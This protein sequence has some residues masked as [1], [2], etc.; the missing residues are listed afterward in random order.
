MPAPL[1]CP[2][3]S[4][5][6]DLPG[7]TIP[8]DK[9]EQYERHFQT[10]AVCQALLDHIDESVQTLVT[11]V[12]EVGA[13]PAGPDDPILRETLERL[14]EVKALPGTPS[15]ERTDLYFLRPGKR[16]GILGMLG[17][18]EV[19]EVI[20]RGGMGIVLKAFDPA[21][22]RPVAIKVMATAALLGSA[23]A[24][25]RFAR[26]AQAAA[27]V[28]HENV[29]TV[30][31][32]DE[33]D[34]LPYL[35][36]QYVA[37]ESLQTRLERT[38]PLEV[39]EIVRIGLQTASGLA[40]AHAQ[41]LIHRDIK[42][43][44]L[45]LEN[46]LPRVK[47]TDFGLARTVDDVQLTQQ[48]EVAGTPQYMAPEQARGE[49]VDHR[50][51]L[52]SLGSV[53]YAMSTGN[54]PFRGSSPWAVIQQVVHKHPR[55]IRDLNPE[56]PDWLEMFIARLMAKDPADRFQSAVEVAE[57]LEGYLAHYRQPR[58]IAAPK[59]PPPPAAGWFQRTA[60][61]FQPRAI[62][63]FVLGLV[64]SVLVLVAAFW[65]AKALWPAGEVEKPTRRWHK[66]YSFQD[67]LEKFPSLEL[68]GPDADAAAKTDAQGLR[69]KVP[70][71]R[72][73]SD[74]DIGVVLP[75]R[76]RGD[77]DISAG[78]ELLSFGQ[79]TPTSGLGVQMLVEFDSAFLRGAKATRLRKPTGD[80]SAKQFEPVNAEGEIFGATVVEKD[81]NLAG[82]VN[83]R[84]LEPKGRLKLTRNGS[85][86]QYWVKDGNSDYHLISNREFGTDDVK[87]IRLF[88]FTGF[89]SVGVDV[90][91]TDLMVEADTNPESIVVS[92]TADAGVPA[93]TETLSSKRWLLLLGVFVG[94]LVVV[95]AGAA[96]WFRSRGGSMTFAPSEAA[97]DVA[98]SSAVSFSCTT[99]GKKLRARAEL[100][101]KKVRCSQCSQAVL[102]PNTT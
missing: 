71:G 19:E 89:K 21:L 39:V 65:L 27:A 86:L 62:K 50:A 22:H 7:D 37:G 56:V 47:I 102:V 51:D 99:C 88:C 79:P 20:G 33:E 55:P 66:V 49:T 17:D 74:L 57:L 92:A 8:Q 69:I 80:S 2:W 58:R 12:R 91:F 67:G 18:Y 101:G 87:M 11:L 1:D 59:L 41:G 29:V 48:G 90:R 5:W 6:Q 16:P 32:V 43:A 23:T 9:I 72:Q 42:P 73:R 78:Y 83:V 98:L 13:T 10:C 93:E 96:Y 64:F 84:A 97:N 61:R 77:F 38:G 26:E 82:V 34:G 35:V 45:L 63:G 53:L 70:A 25:R 44:N 24:R 60:R 76:I 52:F 14:Y 46:G 3:F 68:Y 95:A 15:A 81:G 30:H 94:G 75:L 36:M 54:P 31:G 4:R 28:C 85:E 100:A 40:A